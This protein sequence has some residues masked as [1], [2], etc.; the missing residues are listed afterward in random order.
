[1]TFEKVF[2]PAKRFLGVIGASVGGLTAIFYVIGFLAMQAHHTF[3]GLTHI[4]IDFNKYLFTGGQFFSYFP[5]LVIVL[6]ES[7]FEIIASHFEWLLYA[8]SAIVIV[9][10]L[11]L[12]QLIRRL[13]SH[14]GS[15]AKKLTIRY[16]TVLQ[17]LFNLVLLLLFLEF[18]LEIVDEKNWLFRSTDTASS[19]LI[20]T[21]A[22]GSFKRQEY[23]A[24]LLAMAILSVFALVL[25]EYLRRQPN[26][27][28]NT[29][30]KAPWRSVLFIS[31][32]FLIVLQWLYLPVNYG[33][34]IISNRYPTV[35]IGLRDYQQMAAME[36]DA[37]LF[38]L[39]REGDDYFFYNRKQ[40]K[41]WQVAR[42]DLTWLIRSDEVNIFDQ[43]H[44]QTNKG[45]N[46]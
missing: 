7:L 26:S 12:I 9:R 39:H 36:A 24:K 2:E 15:A 5:V 6:Y 22:E 35:Q 43:T 20:D 3:L 33:I 32:F 14:F 23:F 29:P 34:L 45:D 28:T 18:S 17:I 1:M 46:K 21:T 11:L 27:K 30:V 38:F 37:P 42:T 31:A 40:R 41:I 19:W 8:I 10:L 44:V 16:I 25:L 13:I 4:S